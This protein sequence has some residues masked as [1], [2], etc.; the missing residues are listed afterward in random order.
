MKKPFRRGLVA[1]AVVVAIIVNVLTSY[2]QTA[3][4]SRAPYKN[5]R[6]PVGERVRDLVGRMTVEEKAGQLLTLLG[7]EMYTG[8]AGRMTVSEKFKTEITTRH[9][10]AL[11]ATLRADPWTKKT[12]ANGLNPRTAA[13]AANALQRYAVTRT[14]LGIPL[15]LAEECAHGHMAIGATVFPVPLAQAS[16]FNPEL[17][18]RMAGVTAV[19]TRLQGAHLGYGPI[20]D[21]AR[22][23]RWSRTEETYGED[24]FLMAAMGKAVVKGFQGTD[25][26]SGRNVV[27]TLKHFAAYGTPDGGQNGG[28]VSLG[29]RDLLE[30][31]LPPF[32]A[33]VRAGAGSVMTAYSSID[34]VPGSAD[35][36]LLNEVLRKRWGFNGFVV[37]DLGSIGGLVSGHHVARNLEDAAAMAMNSGL[38]NDLGGE[39]FYLPLL[40]AIKSGK[41]SM[42]R[43]D[44]A[45]ARVLRVKFELGLFENPYVQPKATG[46]VNNAAHKK[47]AREVAEESLVLLKN[48]GDLLPLK[49]KLRR[50]AVIGPNADTQYNQLGDYTAPQPPEKV[51]TILEGLRDALGK[52]TQIDYVKGCSIRDTTGTEIPA[53]VAAAGRAD[54]AIVVLGGSSARDFKTTYLETGAA[55]VK[56]DQ[57]S[58]MESGEGFDRASLDLM[59]RQLELLKAVV[60]TGKPVVL[61]LIEGRPLNINWAAENVP[62]ILNA[63]YPGEQGGH[64]VAAAILGSINPS[65]KLP[66]SIPRSVGQLPVHYNAKFPTRHDYVEESARPRYAFGHGLSYTNFVYSDLKITVQDRLPSPKVTVTLNLKNTGRFAGSEVVQLY[67][68]DVV[69]SVSGPQKQLKGFAKVRLKPGEQQSVSFQLSHQELSMI[70]VHERHVVEAGEFRIMLGSSSEDVRLRGKFD[71]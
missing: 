9:I 50:V 12:L 3:D 31:F 32:E 47:L 64:A 5:A 70:D 1:G 11:W 29:R 49:Q 34:G 41:V 69:R 67:L 22:E 6:L 60:A 8:T 14:R 46:I 7:W 36:F 48:N 62:A 56:E 16:T 21:L 33:A 35:Q 55:A 39:A 28:S 30:N 20:L 25:L 2:A 40:Q 68:T 27:S 57:I 23:P 13:E 15:L 24:P 42:H 65:G 37:S 38:D 66:V 61:V 18:E 19:E 58:D 52:E 54:V 59:G 43:L 10:G 71:L 51:V 44:E 53:A 17:I 4:L 26:K 63:W 45:V